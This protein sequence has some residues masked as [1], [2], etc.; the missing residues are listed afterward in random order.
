[1]PLL[2]KYIPTICSPIHEILYKMHVGCDTLW[3]FLFSG[4]SS[5]SETTYTIGEEVVL[6]CVLD[7]GSTGTGPTSVTWLGQV[8]SLTVTDHYVIDAG[9]DDAGTRTTTLTFASVDSNDFAGT[10]T[11][12]F[13]YPDEETYT[14]TVDVVVRCKFLRSIFQ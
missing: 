14:E 11:C 3:H 5:W 4:L 10:Y 2:L 1:M 7:F 12:Q 13:T 6:S 8:D 9:S